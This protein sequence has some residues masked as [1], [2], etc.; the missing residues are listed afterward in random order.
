MIGNG[1]TVLD[2]ARIGAGTLVAAGAVVT[3]GTVVGDGVLVGGTPARVLRSIEGTSAAAMVEV[4]A[5]YY[6]E[7]AKRH[8]AG[9][10][11]VG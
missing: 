7:L 10:R 3:P 5:P 2:G 8:R 11:P 1:A 9:T 6:V 4:N